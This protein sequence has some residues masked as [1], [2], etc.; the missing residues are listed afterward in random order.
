MSGPVGIRSRPAIR[1]RVRT[2][3]ACRVSDTTVP[4]TSVTDSSAPT[5]TRMNTVDPRH[6]SAVNALSQDIRST[7]RRDGVSR[8]AT[9]ST[10][11]A[12]PWT[13]AARSAQVRQGSLSAVRR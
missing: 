5:Q 11:P 8:A 2:L 9:A 6:T 12:T 3:S 13:T 4:G 10:S 1:W 7:R